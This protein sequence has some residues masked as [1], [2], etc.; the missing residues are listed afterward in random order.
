MRLVNEMW[1]VATEV[2]FHCY[3]LDG[4]YDVDSATR[5]SKINE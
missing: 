3:N 5:Y 1:S 4:E 2:K